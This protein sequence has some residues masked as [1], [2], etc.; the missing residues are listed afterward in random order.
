MESNTTFD[1]AIADL[2]GMQEHLRISSVP[3]E[4]TEIKGDNEI[5]DGEDISMDQEEAGDYYLEFY[6]LWSELNVKMASTIDAQM[7]TYKDSLKKVKELYSTRKN[8]ETL[9]EAEADSVAALKLLDWSRF[10][11]HQNRITI[12]LQ[13][14]EDLEVAVQNLE[15]SEKYHSG[16][17]AAMLL[18]QVCYGLEHFFGCKARV[19]RSWG[20]LEV[21]IAE[22]LKFWEGRQ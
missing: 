9:A 18:T 16:R 21:I 2:T 5:M 6:D 14:L 1:G 11:P 22:E 13:A 15:V 12:A 8:P 7:D 10:Q 3:A 19:L 17:G 4:A 20:Q